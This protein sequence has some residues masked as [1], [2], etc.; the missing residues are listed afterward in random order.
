MAG[1][2]TLKTKGDNHK[3]N[4]FFQ[5]CLRVTHT[6]I[7]DKYGKAGVEAL[8]Y[9]SPKDTGRLADN[10]SYVIEDDGVGTSKIVWLNSDIEGGYNV[11]LL[12]QYGHLKKDGTYLEGTDFINPA[13]KAIFEEFAEEI[14]KELDEL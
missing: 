10:W 7:L 12:V 14:G 11:A 4:S 5:K 2:V 6:S 9:Y 13:M 1:L 8:R 3:L